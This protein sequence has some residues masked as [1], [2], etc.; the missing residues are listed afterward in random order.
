MPKI[1]EDLQ[2]TMILMISEPTLPNHQTHVIHINFNENELESIL[3]F[4]QAAVPNVN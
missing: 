2:V 4:C 3:A 1:E